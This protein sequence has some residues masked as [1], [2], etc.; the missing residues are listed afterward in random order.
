MYVKLSIGAII[1]KWVSDR[2][3]NKSALIR[4]A[5]RKVTTEVVLVGQIGHAGGGVLLCNSVWVTDACT[6][7]GQSDLADRNVVF[8][9]AWVL[10]L[11]SEVDSL[12]AAGKNQLVTIL[13]CKSDRI[14]LEVFLVVED[15]KAVCDLRDRPDTGSFIIVEDVVYE[16]V[17]VSI[18]DLATTDAGSH[19]EGCRQVNRLICDQ[20]VGDN[21]CEASLI[22]LGYLRWVTRVQNVVGE[23]F[24]LDIAVRGIYKVSL[25]FHIV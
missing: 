15:G 23:V 25:D 9:N 14:D 22:G 4:A 6:D 17:H 5:E 1:D 12:F 19:G 7:R 18:L 10:K 8:I 11:N 20:V 16:W 2:R 13:I 24:R 21:I 3:V